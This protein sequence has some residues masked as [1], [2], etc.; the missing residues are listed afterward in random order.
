[1][2]VKFHKNSENIGKILKISWVRCH[3]LNLSFFFFSGSHKKYSLVLL[4]ITDY[5]YSPWKMQKRKQYCLE[6]SVQSF[7]P[8]KIG[9]TQFPDR[10]RV[11]YYNFPP[12]CGY[13]VLCVFFLTILFLSIGGFQFVCIAF[14]RC[15]DKWFLA[16]TIIRLT[17][18]NDF[19]AQIAYF[20]VFWKENIH[21]N[22][23]VN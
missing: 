3:F 17:N 14:A 7:C 9:I 18:K 22:K 10:F 13:F 11:K 12:F 2:N 23:K 5:I 21:G 16:V 8:L 15:C 4:H 19:I 20:T 6:Y 1:M